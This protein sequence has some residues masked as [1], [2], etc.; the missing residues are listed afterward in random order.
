MGELRLDWPVWIGVVA[1]DLEA[2]RRFYREVLGLRELQAT[3]EWVEFDLGSGR[4][5]EVLAL[6]P[7]APQYATLGYSVGFLV[8]DIRAAA[9]EL[10][11]RGVRR[12]SE[13]EGGPDSGQYWCYFEDGEGNRFE[14]AQRTA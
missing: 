10:V 3:E 4:K 13:I 1:E 11:A 9:N 7:E 6:D 2:Q 5:L 12:I 14:I 8:D